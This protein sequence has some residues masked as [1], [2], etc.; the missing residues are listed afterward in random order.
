MHT[1]NQVLDL[2]AEKNAGCTDYRLSKLM[3]VTTQ[4]VAKWR[5]GEA[6]LSPTMAL[7]AAELLNWPPEYLVACVEHER[8]ARDSRH[9]IDDTGEI[10]ATWQSIAARFRP[11]GVPTILIAGLLW[12]LSLIPEP[13]QALARPALQNFGCTV[14]TLCE[15]ADE[16]GR[17]RRRR[18]KKKQKPPPAK[19]GQFWESVLAAA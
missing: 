13:A 15:V 10:K 14:D 1:T 9:S 4:A 3:R 5:H 12:G 17:R 11:A 18:S 7:R 16:L 6:V 2:I 8:A 19:N